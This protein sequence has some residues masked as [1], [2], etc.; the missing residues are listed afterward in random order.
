MIEKTEGLTMSN[1]NSNEDD[2]STSNSSAISDSKE[3]KD[4]DK[5]ITQSH[6]E[7]HESMLIS[8]AAV[9]DS[10]DGVKQTAQIA[11]KT[12]ANERNG[13]VAASIDTVSDVV[14]AHSD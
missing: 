2:E 14:N 4:N 3:V 13:S 5:S 8:E 12:D 11:N 1:N 6:A 7:V 10:V 9:S